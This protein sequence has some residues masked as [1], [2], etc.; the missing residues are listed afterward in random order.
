MEDHHHR[1]AVPLSGFPFLAYLLIPYTSPKKMLSFYIGNFRVS[2]V[3]V[4][5][6]APAGPVPGPLCRA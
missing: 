3:R 1:A 4:A 6:I 2:V 5:G